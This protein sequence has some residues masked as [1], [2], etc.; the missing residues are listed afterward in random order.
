MR[1]IAR[2]LKDN[3]YTKYAGCPERLIPDEDTLVKALDLHEEKV[4]VVRDG[5]D[6]KGVAVFLT[7]SDYSYSRIE[8]LNV[9]D[10]DT[11]AA[12]LTERG[13]NLHFILLTAENIRI[14]LAG[15]RKAKALN[16]KTISWWNPEMTK[17]H[18]YNFE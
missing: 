13:R 18:R 5:E 3:Y 15:I 9:G 11:L 2:Y 12:L 14:I 1:E 17:L 8:A 16:P 7:L 6:I 4:V 10:Q